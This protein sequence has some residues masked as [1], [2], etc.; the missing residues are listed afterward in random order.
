M[1]KTNFLRLRSFQLVIVSQIGMGSCVSTLDPI[2]P[3]QETKD[4]K[5]K[6]KPSHK[7]SIWQIKERKKAIR[8]GTRIR[9]PLVHTLRNSIKLMI[10]NMDFHAR[11]YAVR[12][13][14]EHVLLNGKP[15]RD[16]TSQ[17]SGKPPVD[18]TER[19]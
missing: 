1:D 17:S 3:R 7:T 12:E 8:G 11:H 15:P 6:Q 2:L 10:T 4:N 9:N 13:T 18:E 19:G 5:I 14:L 16:P